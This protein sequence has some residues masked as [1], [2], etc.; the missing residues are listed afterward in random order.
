MENKPIHC[1]LYILTRGKYAKM[2]ATSKDVELK[3]VADIRFIE[4][5]TENTKTIYAEL[6]KE[7]VNK[8]TPVIKTYDFTD[9]KERRIVVAWK[10]S[11]APQYFTEVRQFHYF[12]YF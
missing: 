7:A 10:Q 9:S 5:A 11:A 12:Y 2:D 1:R 4:R 6:L 8:L 3:D